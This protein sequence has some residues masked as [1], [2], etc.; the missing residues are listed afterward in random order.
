MIGKIDSWYSWWQTLTQPQ[1]FK[2][3]LRDRCSYTSL[4][5][6]PSVT[7]MPAS[8][9]S[10]SLWLGISAFNQE[11][12]V[13]QWCLSLISFFIFLTHPNQSKITLLS[14]P[15]WFLFL[16]NE[17]SAQPCWMRKT[18]YCLHSDYIYDSMFILYTKNIKMGKS[19]SKFK[20]ISADEKNYMKNFMPL[21][22][23]RQLKSAVCG[24]KT[25][26]M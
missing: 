13:M 25:K 9:F 8:L 22:D 10:T 20:K 16:R 1:K 26:K 7:L 6:V 21:I 17:C 15:T 12:I 4:L 24:Q 2:K 11:Q 14:L 3:Q 23:S 5:L 18:V 19:L